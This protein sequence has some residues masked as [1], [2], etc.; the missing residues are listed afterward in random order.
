MFNKKS[1]INDKIAMNVARENRNAS[2]LGSGVVDLELPA[3]KV[4]LTNPPA[5]Y[6]ELPEPYKNEKLSALYGHIEDI[7]GQLFDLTHDIP[8]NYNGF[9]RNM[10]SFETL[11]K[12]VDDAINEYIAIASDILHGLHTENNGLKL[13]IKRLEEKVVQQDKA[14][15]RNREILHQFL[16]QQGIMVQ[17]WRDFYARRI[18]THK[19]AS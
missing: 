6:G 13:K 4:I 10:G 8:S 5:D 16:D 3:G 19:I 7:L 14:Q 1:N 2:S 18:Q 12:L 15:N 17:N 9:I 11:A